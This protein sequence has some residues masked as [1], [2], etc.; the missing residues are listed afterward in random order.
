MSVHQQVEK[1]LDA[2]ADK[3][4][5]KAATAAHLDEL[6]RQAAAQHD[7]TV[8]PRLF[9]QLK[10]VLTGATRSS[11]NT[12]RLLEIR[13]KPHWIYKDYEWTRAGTTIYK[14]Y[15][16]KVRLF[17]RFHLLTEKGVAAKVRTYMMEELLPPGAAEI[18]TVEFTYAKNW[19]RG[20]WPHFYDDTTEDDFH[21]FVFLGT[22]LITRPL[23][24]IYDS[25]FPRISVR[26]VFSIPSEN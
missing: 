25:L 13:E 22:P 3:V 10:A 21:L 4:A 15:R 12:V 11:G 17:G 16:L 5:T 14:D 18:R 19:W 24:W 20:D 9:S 1:H 7:D 26:V 2:L 6:R 8:L 23:A